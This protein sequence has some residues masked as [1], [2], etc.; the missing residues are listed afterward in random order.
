MY[1][2]ST[3]EGIHTI[4]HRD[5]TWRGGLTPPDIQTFLRPC[6]V[7]CLS[8]NL[9][10]LKMTIRKGLLS[11][12]NWRFFRKYRYGVRHVIFHICYHIFALNMFC[13][14]SEYF[15]LVRFKFWR[16]LFFF[17]FTYNTIEHRRVKFVKSC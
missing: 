1:S 17:L 14:K 12:K 4:Y 5:N 6:L 3:R 8:E 16:L 15:I 10:S 11:I 9:H 13:K 7:F 2:Y